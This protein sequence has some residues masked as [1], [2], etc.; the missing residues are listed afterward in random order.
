[1]CLRFVE[2]LR[3]AGGEVLMVMPQALNR[4]AWQLGPVAEHLQDADYF[5]PILHL[6]GVL[7]TVPAE[8]SRGPYLR[9]DR[10]LDQ[11]STRRRVGIAW[12]VGKPSKGDYPREVPLDLLVKAFPGDELHSVQV[13]N[14]EE[15]EKHG[16]T[17]HTLYD[18]V[19][20]ASLMA[21]MDVVV[22]ID[23]AALHLAGAIGHPHAYGLLSYWASWRWVADWYPG[24][25]MCRQQQ[26]GDWASALAQVS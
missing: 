4:L 15:A 21:S 8:V 2:Q 25:K 11:P 23:T 13:Q 24:M 10:F 19:D 3:E 1:M 5:C 20:C 16:I 22:S 18:F 6:P 7:Q 17:T 26:P 12:S 14:G 9:T